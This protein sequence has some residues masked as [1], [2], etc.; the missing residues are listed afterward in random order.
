MILCSALSPVHRNRLLVLVSAK[1]AVDLAAEG[2]LL[3]AGTDDLPAAYRW[4]PIA[5]MDLNALSLNK[6]KWRQD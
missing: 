5:A 3:H 1:L 4:V 2:F 6:S